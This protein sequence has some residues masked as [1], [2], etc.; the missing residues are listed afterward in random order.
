MTA[1]RPRKRSRQLRQYWAADTLESLRELEPRA[2]TADL[3]LTDVHSPEQRSRNMAAIRGK[4]TKPE[5]KVRTMLHALGYRFR[6][7]RKD[8]PGT[9]DIILP[10]HRVA[11]FVNG[12]FW[13]RHNCGAGRVVPSTRAEFWATKRQDTVQRDKRKRRQLKAVGWNVLTIWECSTK[14]PL[15]LEAILKAL[16]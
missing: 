13:H 15:K 8:L 6:L 11:I 7:H 3:P 1:I 5:L 4:H 12:C 2:K 10:K 14:D 9:P 16:P